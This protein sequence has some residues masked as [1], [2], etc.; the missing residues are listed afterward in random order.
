VASALL[1]HA[2]SPRHRRLL[3]WL[4]GLR[5][6]RHGVGPRLLALIVL[7]SSAVTLALTSLELYVDYRRDVDVVKV[8]IDEIDLGYGGSIANSLWNLDAK[9][10]QIQLDGMLLLP[11]IVAAEIREIGRAH[12]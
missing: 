1:D 10:L 5:R 7:F 2:P 8:R 9:G 4:A 11:D 6:Q 12:V 3:G